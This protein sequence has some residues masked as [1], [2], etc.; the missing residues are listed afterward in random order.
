M[1]PA[2]EPWQVCLPHYDHL[3]S[4]GS[5]DPRHRQQAVEK[6]ERQGAPRQLIA[7]AYEQKGRLPAYRIEPERSG[8]GEGM[9]LPPLQPNDA[10]EKQMAE[11]RSRE[12]AQEQ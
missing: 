9:G 3:M 1:N 11:R 6:L 2:R 12:L 7:E 8:P 4:L 10:V 5:P